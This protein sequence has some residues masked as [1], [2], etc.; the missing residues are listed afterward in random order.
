MSFTDSGDGTGYVSGTPQAGSGGQYPVTITASNGVGIPAVQDLAVTVDESPAITSANNWTSTIGVTSTF[1]VTTA[2]GY[3]AAYTLAELGT[4][5]AGLSLSISGE[6]ATISGIPTG[7]PG[8][9]P[10]TLTASNGVAPDTVQTLILTVADANAVPLPLTPPVGGGVITGVP[11]ATHPGESFTA[12]A[13]GFAPGAP[14]TWGIYSSPQ[15][16]ASTIADSSGMA[17][18]QVTIPAG[19][20]GVHTVVAIGVAPDGSSLA[21]SATTTVTSPTTLAQLP[22]TGAPLGASPDA[23]LLLLGIGILLMLAA[24]LRRRR[25]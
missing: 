12:T 18:A 16:L 2:A 9:D 22:T 10:I 13:S 23:A 5:P 19:F 21:D 6:S 15:N 25:A 7:P 24:R 3:P 8:D 11:A 14:I 17:S 20:V 1:T 4:L